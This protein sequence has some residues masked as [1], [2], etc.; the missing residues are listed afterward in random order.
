M[1]ALVL[2]GS[3]RS[4]LAATRALGRAGIHVGVA[5]C[6]PRMLA[7][8][9]KYCWASGAYPEPG[10]ESSRLAGAVVALLRDQERRPV[11]LPCSDATLPLLL[12]APELKPLCHM[13]VPSAAAYER[14]SDKWSLF[15]LARE[16]G[17]PSP[18]TWLLPGGVRDCRR[19][20]PR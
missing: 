16:L 14:L 15:Q 9:S 2:D 6:V 3:Q 7:A 4:A 17:V 1:H 19:C 13:C 8:N 20:R 12:G 11:L 18:D 5:D 10:Q